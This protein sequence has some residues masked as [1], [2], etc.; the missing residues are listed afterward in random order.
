MLTSLSLTGGVLQLRF[1]YFVRSRPEAPRS[2]PFGLVQKL[3]LKAQGPP[4]REILVTFFVVTD[5]AG[6]GP[7]YRCYLEDARRRGSQSGIDHR[8]CLPGGSPSRL[9]SNRGR[10]DTAVCLG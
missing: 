2:I 1:L 7:D 3:K 6:R 5:P 10:F 8:S 4:F 9:A